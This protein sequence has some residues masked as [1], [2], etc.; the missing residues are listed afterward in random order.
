MQP[1]LA[2]AVLLLRP[3]TLDDFEPLRAIAADPL[4]WEQHPSKDR[5]EAAGFQRWFDEALAQGALVAVDRANGE[6]IG[7]SRFAVHDDELVE[8]GWTF[9]ARSRW[10]GYWNTEMKRI[11]LGHAFAAVSTVGFAVHEDNLRSQRAV[12]RLGAVHIGKSFDSHG[13]GRNVLFHLTKDRWVDPGPAVAGVRVVPYS[14]TWPT[15]FAQ[16]AERLSVALAPWLVG[17]VEHIGSTA[18]PGLAAKPILDMLAPVGDHDEARAAVPALA[19]LGYRQDDH[20]THEALWFY[21][22]QDE[23]YDTRTHQLHLTGA[24][25]ALWRERLTFRD[26]IRADPALLVEYK[27]LKQTLATTSVNLSHYTSGKRDLV[28]R[29]LANKGLKLT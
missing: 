4:L 3:L 17:H 22:Q 13:R 14:A 26:A 23:D 5:A 2:G 16:E 20:R 19:A 8:I 25:S 9:L 10:A 1:V 6:V 24:D 21:K 11:M 7:T 28:S 27:D 29:V 15:L 18:V 12:E